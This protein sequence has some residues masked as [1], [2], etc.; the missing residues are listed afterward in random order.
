MTL[1]EYNGLKFYP[2]C[3]NPKCLSLEITH[4]D[5]NPKGKI[6]C[7]VCEEKSDKPAKIWL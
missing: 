4:L 3:A 2:C 5:D 1:A 7:R 6:V